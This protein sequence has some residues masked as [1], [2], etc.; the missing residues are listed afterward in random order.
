LPPAEHSGLTEPPVV[1]LAEER[2]DE[3]KPADMGELG[4]RPP[5]PTRSDQTAEGV[6][7]E[8]RCWGAPASG[9]LTVPTIESMASPTDEA[10]WTA[11]PSLVRRPGEADGPE[12]RSTD[13]RLAI[14]RRTESRSRLPDRGRPS[15]GLDD[16]CRRAGG[17]G[18]SGAGG[19]ASRSGGAEA[20]RRG[21][22]MAGDRGGGEAAAAEVVVVVVDVDVVDVDV[23]DPGD[24]G[25][26][27]MVRPCGTGGGDSELGELGLA[28]RPGRLGDWADRRTDRAAVALSGMLWPRRRKE[29]EKTSGMLARS[30]GSSLSIR[31]T[32]SL[33][34]GDRPSS[35]L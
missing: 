24:T 19:G 26:G 7:F 10:R 29:C 15:P 3:G 25:R 33:A 18:E 21:G 9:L 13:S 16:G 22:D 14:P 2:G 20:D 4:G 23:A 17:P 32:R 6:E 27:D 5:P 31:R 12:G 11:P 30:A 34:S 28:A 8:R 1:E 35:I